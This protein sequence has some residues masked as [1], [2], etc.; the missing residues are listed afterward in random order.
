MAESLY[1]I[2][3]KDTSANNGPASLKIAADNIALQLQAAA[4]RIQ[5][6]P[7]AIYSY[8]RQDCQVE[9]PKLAEN[10]NTVIPAEE[11]LPV[12]NPV[13]GEEEM[14]QILFKDLRRT[15]KSEKILKCLIQNSGTELDVD[16]LTTATSI[17]RNDL[18]SWMAVTGSRIPAITRPSRGT[19]KFNPDKLNTT[20]NHEQE[21]QEQR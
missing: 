9:R 1:Y 5:A 17:G 11:P 14:L 18:S 21:E 6:D 15:Q 3:F 12:F 2:V 4:D 19:Y 8:L 20:I 7:G 10:E 16:Q 13:A